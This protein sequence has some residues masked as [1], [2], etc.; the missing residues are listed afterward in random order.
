[1]F[2]E[3]GLGFGEWGALRSPWQAREICEER[4]SGEGWVIW[5]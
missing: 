3:V 5:G 2:A 1:M 4:A